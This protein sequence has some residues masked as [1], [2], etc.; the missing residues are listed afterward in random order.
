MMRYTRYRLHLHRVIDVT[1]CNSNPLLNE[2]RNGK[3][4]VFSNLHCQTAGMSCQFLPDKDTAHLNADR[5]PFLSGT[6]LACQT[7]WMEDTWT[8]TDT[9]RGNLL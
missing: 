2:H 7:S 8:P 5:A 1:V 4:I 6:L 9:M 3:S